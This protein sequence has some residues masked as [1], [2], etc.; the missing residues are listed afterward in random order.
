MS[1]IKIEINGLDNLD[2]MINHVSKIRSAG[3]DKELNDYIKGKVLDT[4]KEIMDREL[5]GGTTNDEYINLYKGSYHIED[6][7]DGFI[8]YNDA[9]IPQNEVNSKNKQSYPKGFSIAMAFEY[10][11]GIVGI[12]TGN[13]NAWKYNVHKYKDGWKYKDKNGVEQFT[14]GHTGFEI[15]R[16]TVEQVNQNLNTWVNEYY[17]KGRV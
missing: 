6:T 1:N 7:T 13:P 11:V 17:K 9:L 2:K 10:G 15:F 14:A 3:T 5:S 12:S 4:Y 8:L 16:K